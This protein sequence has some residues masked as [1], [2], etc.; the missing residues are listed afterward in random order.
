[1]SLDRS[2]VQYAEG[3]MFEDG[4]FDAKKLEETE[5]CRQIFE[6]CEGSDVRDAGV[7]QRQ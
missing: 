5:E 6:G 1:M 3:H 7:E 2:D 4:K